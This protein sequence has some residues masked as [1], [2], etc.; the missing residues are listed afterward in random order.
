VTKN[1]VNS[2]QMDKKVNY[3]L[4]KLQFVNFCTL[5]NMLGCF[6]PNLGQIW[7]NPIVGLNM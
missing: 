4:Y 3:N 7:T 2:S 6:N 5:K 1:V